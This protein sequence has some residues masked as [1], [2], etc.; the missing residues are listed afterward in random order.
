LPAALKVAVPVDG[1]SDELRDLA[2]TQTPN[3]AARRQRQAEFRRGKSRTAMDEEGPELAAALGILFA[4][5]MFGFII[6]HD[7]VLPYAV[8][9]GSATSYSGR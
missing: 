2:A 7:E 6:E 3:S 8:A 1:N 9:G 4:V 5:Q